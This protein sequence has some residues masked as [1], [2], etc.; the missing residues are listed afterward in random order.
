MIQQSI[1]DGDIKISCIGHKQYLVEASVREAKMLCEIDD[2]DVSSVLIKDGPKI[3]VGHDFKGIGTINHIS[4]LRD[5]PR[6]PLLL[7]VVLA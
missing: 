4:V 5:N 1:C 2:F 7:R 3:T 6:L